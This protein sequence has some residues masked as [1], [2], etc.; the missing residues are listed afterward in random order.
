MN[1]MAHAWCIIREAHMTAIEH[2]SVPPLRVGVVGS[3]TMGSMI[4]LSMARA[5]HHVSIYSND[6]TSLSRAQEAIHSALEAVEDRSGAQQLITT[7]ESLAAVLDEA[8]LIIE[9]IPENAKLKSEL[10][11]EIA[12]MS[13]G[14]ALIWSNT[15][16]L[17]VFSLANKTLTPRLLIAHWIH[18]AHILPLV[19]V[20]PGPGTE[21]KFTDKTLSILRS[22]GKAPIVMSKYIPGFAINRILRAINREA[23]YL[24]QNGFISVED[25]DIAVRASIAPRMMLLG[26]FQRTDFTDL[27]ISASNLGNPDFV[28][29]PV[30]LTPAVLLDRIEEG[31][32]GIKSG[33]GFYDYG[34]L[35]EQEIL[36]RYQAELTELMEATKKWFPKGRLV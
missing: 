12:S 2:D 13:R 14:D 26:I 6:P 4:A 11:D 20:V 19:E 7:S 29:A 22:L 18:P 32:I 9:A 15:S 36:N 24:V 16:S 25:L 27:R 33:K 21:P 23:F 5:G 1:H 30:D 17:D 35:S 3:G 10:F 28:D 8:D 31:A 34:S